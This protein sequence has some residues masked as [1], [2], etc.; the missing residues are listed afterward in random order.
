MQA[1]ILE[2]FMKIKFLALLTVATLL[3][4]HH[5][6]GQENHEQE[7]PLALVLSLG[8]KEHTI[9]ANAEMR[10]PGEF[11]NP[12]VKIRPAGYR[13]FRRNDI[14]FRYPEDMH[15]DYEHAEGVKSWDLE[16]DDAELNVYCMQESSEQFIQ[17]A[18]REIVSV[19]DEPKQKVKIK[20]GVKKVSGVE[21]KTYE[22]SID[23]GEEY[24]VNT[25]ALEL[26]PTTENRMLLFSREFDGKK[27]VKE[28]VE[29]EKLVLGSLKWSSSNK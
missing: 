4:N 10:I 28:C 23:F 18:I 11:K 21:L 25:Y 8:G 27:L 15:F 19:A 5:L 9:E 12:N 1:L 29:F 26:P 17:S 13:L 6:M 22:Y 16:G 14:S 2:R 3:P 24:W 7:P 20:R